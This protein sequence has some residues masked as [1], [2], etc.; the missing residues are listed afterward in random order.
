[1]MGSDVKRFVTN[2]SHVINIH[3]KNYAVQLIRVVA[4]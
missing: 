1:L 2:R 4:D 3:V